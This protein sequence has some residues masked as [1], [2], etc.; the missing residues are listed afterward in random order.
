MKNI[1]KILFLVSP[2]IIALVLL[3]A[4]WAGKNEQSD[5]AEREAPIHKAF[6]L[7]VKD[8][9]TTLTVDDVA[10]ARSGIQVKIL[11]AAQAAAG[12]L[13]Y[14]TVADVQPLLDLSSRYAAGAAELRAAQA[15]LDQRDAELKRVQAL[16]DDGQNASRKAL[17]A[18]RTDAAAARARAGAAHIAVEAAAAALHQQ[19]GPLLA[20]WAMAPSS[21]DLRALASRRDVLVRVVSMAPGQQA[22]QSLALSGD[23]GKAFTARLVSASPQTD[24][25]MQGLAWFYRTTAPLPAGARLAGRVDVRLQSGI[26]IPADA[27]VWYGG[28]P[29][30]WVRTAGTVFERRRIGQGVL[31]DGGFVVSQGFT[32]GD[33]VVVQGAQLLLSEESRAL[34]RND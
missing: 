31:D 5:E 25:G 12:P 16:Y 10:Q 23:T 26:R 20:A 22:P 19:F 15:E 8:G 30:A 33:A 28:Q 13:V 7:A 2:T 1:V 34:L 32:P 11:A 29:W 18:A 4:H 6:A 17:D 9:V 21:Q 27:V 24:P 3:A 14:G